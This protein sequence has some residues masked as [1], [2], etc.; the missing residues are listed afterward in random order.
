MAGIRYDK[1][2]A[3]KARPTMFLLDKDKRILG[4]SINHAALEQLIKRDKEM[5]KSQ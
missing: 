4:K 2:Y 5:K 3:L 1:L